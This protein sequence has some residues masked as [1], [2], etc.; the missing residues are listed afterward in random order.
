MLNNAF[1]PDTMIILFWPSKRLTI[2]LFITIIS[3]TQYSAEMGAGASERHSGKY[4]TMMTKNEVKK[5]VIYRI[6][7]IENREIQRFCSLPY[8]VLLLKTPLPR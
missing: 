2:L 3:R 7:K 1:D 5:T 6:V 8:K 4:T